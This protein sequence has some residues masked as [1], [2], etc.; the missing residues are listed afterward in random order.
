[1]IELNLKHHLVD[2]KKDFTDLLL[3]YELYG[4]ED[5]SNLVDSLNIIV[6]SIEQDDFYIPVIEHKIDKFG[7]AEAAI[8][9]ANAGRNIN[10]IALILS[11]TSGIA[12]TSS[13][14]EDWYK[15]YS[16]IKHTRS[17]KAYGNIFNVQERMQQIYETLMD[18]LKLIENTP[19]E[20]FF[21]AKTTREQVTLEV[22][23]DVRSITKD[24]KE[25]LKTINHYQRFEEFKFLVIETIRSIDPATAQIITDKI[26]QDKALF[27]A[28]L[29]PV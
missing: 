21:K 16:N 29:P 11:T 12:I 27:N 26:Q 3:K 5:I 25:I 17:A 20:E 8:N 22:L 15:N 10:D 2:F 7:I 1:M 19:K 4:K 9:L 13:E 14:L 23:K 28:L 18:H 24:A 6:S